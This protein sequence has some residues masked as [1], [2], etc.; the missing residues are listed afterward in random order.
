MF[1]TMFHG[2]LDLATAA[3]CFCNAGH[4]SPYLLRARNGRVGLPAMGIPFGIDPEMEYLIGETVLARGD[5]LLMFSDGITDICI[6]EGEAYGNA[7]LECALEAV[8]EHSAIEIVTHIL[9]ENSRLLSE[10]KKFDDRISSIH[11]D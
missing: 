10:A 3:L 4:N 6:P 2:V 9:A 1:V 7:R 8:R 5:A 11:T